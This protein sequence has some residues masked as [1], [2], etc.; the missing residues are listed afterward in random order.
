MSRA[1]R[2]SRTGAAASW[3]AIKQTRRKRATTFKARLRRLKTLAKVSAFLA[4]VAVVALIV[5]GSFLLIKTATDRFYISGPSESLQKI[6]FHTNGVLND[7]WLRSQFNPKR[8]TSLMDVDILRLKAKLESEGQVR[9]AKIERQFPATLAIT[10]SEYQP[11]AKVAVRT[12]KRKV[13][14]YLVSAEGIVYEGLGYPQPVLDAIPF[15]EGVALHK[16][17]NG[18][19]P[20]RGMDALSDLLERAR[21]DKPNLYSN[22]KVA[23]FRNFSGDPDEVGATIVIKTQNVGQVVFS[24]NNFEE[25]LDRLDYIVHYVQEQNIRSV[26]KIDL[27]LDDHAA[28]QIAVRDS[29]KR[30]F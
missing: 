13:R 30:R 11:V 2:K 8:T 18:Y 16:T 3:K 22:W 27:T 5:F 1:Q 24:P 7:V 4:M 6:A 25:Q 20:I 28:V 19:R 17:K 12:K 10:L 21:R 14:Q 15:L 9:Q 23:S 29:K 26:Q